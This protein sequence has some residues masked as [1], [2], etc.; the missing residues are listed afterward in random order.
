MEPQYSC[1][2]ATQNCFADHLKKLGESRVEK[3][4]AEIANEE[5]NGGCEEKTSVFHHV[6]RSDLPL[7]EKDPARLKREAISLL[8]AGTL[9]TSA[10]LSI[11]VYYVLANP[12]IES[13]LRTELKN[14]TACYPEQVPTWASLEKVPYLVGC[15]KEGLRF[16]YQCS[17]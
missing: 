15:I 1:I 12:D 6:L 5:K 9:T 8:A 2:Y 17:P 3:I 11:T 16:A 7:S 4:K 10:T 13:R 14:I